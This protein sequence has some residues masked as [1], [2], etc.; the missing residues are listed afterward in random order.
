MN[1][2]QSFKDLV[3]NLE[4]NG[5]LLFTRLRDKVPD[6]RLK[7]LFNYLAAEEEDHAQQ[8][9]TMFSS[10]KNAGILTAA[11]AKISEKMSVIFE[12]SVEL[13]ILIQR[14]NSEETILGYALGI[15]KKSIDLYTGLIHQL[16]D[17]DLRNMIQKILVEERNHYE[18]ISAI[19]KLQSRSEKDP[20]TDMEELEK[21]L[22]NAVSL[23][24]VKK[25]QK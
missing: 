13:D 23:D 10:S 9:E 21:N 2:N 16:S 24:E 15:E 17:S 3:I 8:I 12:K 20:L 5:A 14:L 25:D 11:F 4:K 1:Q 18:S 7:D 22:K 6:Q 19:L